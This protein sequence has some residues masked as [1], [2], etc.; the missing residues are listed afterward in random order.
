MD[1]GSNDQI[2]KA[3]I[4]GLHRQAQQDARSRQGR[5][6][7]THPAGRHVLRLPLSAARRALPA[8]RAPTGR[9]RRSHN[10]RGGG[11]ETA[12]WPGRP[13]RCPLLRPAGQQ[14]SPQ[15]LVP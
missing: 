4:A 8:E 11:S 14:A 13:G 10:L 7:P 12:E 5:R 9:H 6:P 3:R 2:A 15:G 1:T